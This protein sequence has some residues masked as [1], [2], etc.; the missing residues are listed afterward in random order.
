[1]RTVFIVLMVL[2]ALAVVAVAMLNQEIVMVNYIFGQVELPL[3]AVILGSALA[4]VL[5]MVFFYIYRSIHNYVKSGSG[6]LQ[7]GNR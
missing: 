5:I 1:M 6:K 2:L 3:I 4:D 7:M